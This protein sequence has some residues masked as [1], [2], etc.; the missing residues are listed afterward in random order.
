MTITNIT[1]NRCA[2]RVPYEQI[3]SSAQR[4]RG[5]CDNELGV[6]EHVQFMSKENRKRTRGDAGLPDVSDRLHTRKRR[7]R[8]EAGVPKEGGTSDD[9]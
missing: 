4:E 9:S 1:E 2:E 6:A 8:D 5:E 3:A 7:L